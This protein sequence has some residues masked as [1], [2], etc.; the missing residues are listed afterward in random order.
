MR[1]SWDMRFSIFPVWSLD[2]PIGSGNFSQQQVRG[3]QSFK[4]FPPKRTFAGS[5]FHGVFRKPTE[6]NRPTDPPTKNATI[7]AYGGLPGAGQRDLVA[8]WRQFL[9]RS[10]EFEQMEIEYFIDPEVW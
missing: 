7:R 6:S 3:I 1:F 8:G 4:R 9:F 5:F 10:R 2:L